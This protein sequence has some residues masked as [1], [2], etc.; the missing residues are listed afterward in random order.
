MPSS[1]PFAEKPAGINIV[2][3]DPALKP[4]IDKAIDAGIPVMTLDA[5]VYGSK[6]FTFLGTGNYNA[7]RVGAQTLAEAIGSKGKVALLTK[8]GQSNL[9]ERIQG[10]KDEFAENYPE[11]EMVPRLSIHSPILR[12]LRMG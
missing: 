2:G 3:F 11:I 4:S 6:R 12:R 8:V 9:E 7:G 1:R 5:E 10:Y